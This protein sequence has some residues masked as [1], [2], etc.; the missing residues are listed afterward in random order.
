MQNEELSNTVDKMILNFKQDKNKIIKTEGM[1]VLSIA[2]AVAL[3]YVG[4]VK[5]FINPDNYTNIALGIDSLFALGAIGSGAY[6]FRN[7]ERKEDIKILKQKIE[8]L[9]KIKKELN[10]GYNRFEA[11]SIDVFKETFDLIF[12]MSYYPEYVKKEYVENYH[13][14]NEKGTIRI[15]RK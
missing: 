14:N 7:P 13:E 11:L 1:E 5:H 8:C 3:L 10:Y 4:D 2:A 9:N 15:K 12:Y 6:V